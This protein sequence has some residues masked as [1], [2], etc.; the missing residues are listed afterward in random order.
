TRTF[1]DLNQGRPFYP[2]YDSRHD[3]SVVAAYKLNDRWELSATWTYATGQPYTFAA[4]QYQ[5]PGLRHEDQ[6]SISTGP[7]LD[8]SGRNT[9][10]LPAF[11]KLDL[12]ATYSFMMFDIP[13]QFSMNIYNA[14][15]HRNIFSQYVEKT[16]VRDPASGLRTQ[17]LQLH[18]VSLFP[19]IPTVGLSCAF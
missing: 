3:I 7:R 5:F 4:G 15:N 13:W 9:H 12:N 18:Q 6:S 8:Y 16:I 11:H 14:Y 17:G 19:I 10:R 1:A 2:R